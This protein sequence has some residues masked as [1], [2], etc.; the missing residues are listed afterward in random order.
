MQ[1]TALLY[2]N[3]MVETIG[4][5]GRRRGPA[6][7]VELRNSSPVVTRST[8]KLAVCSG[9]RLNGVRLWYSCNIV[10]LC[11]FGAAGGIIGG[12]LKP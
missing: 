3:Q 9:V 1:T 5:I 12:G 2:A 7:A 6:A 11:E 8:N 4:E 10:Q